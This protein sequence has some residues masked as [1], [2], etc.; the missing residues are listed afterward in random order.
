MSYF[1]RLP[2][3]NVFFSEQTVMQVRSEFRQD[4]ARF[5]REIESGLN[6][7]T[8]S[9]FERLLRDSGL[10]IHYQRY[11]CI[12]RWNWLARLPWLREF[13]INQISVSVTQQ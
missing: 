4:G 11:T 1:C 9:R 6:Q 3:V 10:R 5:Y 2:W 7:M 13:F 8:V 12:K